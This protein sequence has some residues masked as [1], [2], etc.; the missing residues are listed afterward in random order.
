MK[1]RVICI[2]GRLFSERA[3]ENDSAALLVQYVEAV[4]HIVK[5]K[6]LESLRTDCEWVFV[7][8]LE[9]PGQIKLLP[10]MPYGDYL[11]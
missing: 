4:A 5:E 7:P 10:C 11:I 8:S 2:V 3:S 9:D 1:P 6:Q